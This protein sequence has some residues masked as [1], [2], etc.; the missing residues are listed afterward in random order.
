MSFI[1]IYIYLS[2]NVRTKN[3]SGSAVY[4]R[5]TGP[6]AIT[7]KKLIGPVKLSEISQ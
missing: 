7:G 2:F 5:D 4:A 3:L 1:Y 6:Y